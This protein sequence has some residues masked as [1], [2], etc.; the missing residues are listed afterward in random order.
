[1]K[2]KL[3]PLITII[4]TS[5]G[6]PILAQEEPALSM[7]ETEKAA[8][9]AQAAAFSAAYIAGDVNAIMALYTDDARIIPINGRILADQASIRQLWSAAIASPSKATS[10]E[11]VSDKLVIEGSIATD[12]GYYYGE[13][14]ARNGQRNAFGG[15]YMIVWK[16]VGGVWR[17]HLDMW[18]TV[19]GLK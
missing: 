1:M 3:V 4:I 5:F 10:H 6:L 13:S 17:K 9:E 18:N 7:E 2:K 8:I 12:V 11:A 19:R 16:K 14:R 15:A